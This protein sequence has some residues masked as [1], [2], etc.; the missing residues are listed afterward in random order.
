MYL[1]V[2]GRARAY[3]TQSDGTERTLSVFEPGA[4]FGEMALLTH[5]TRSA[6]V[7]AET[8]SEILALDYQALERIRMRFPYT[9]AK[10]FRNL[11]HMLS[12]RLRRATGDLVG[13]ARVRAVAPGLPS[14]LRHPAEDAVS[15]R[16]P[17]D[18]RGPCPEADADCPARST[19][20]WPAAASPAPRSRRRFGTADTR[21]WWSSRDSTGPSGCPGS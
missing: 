7:V 17:P 21:C 5:E 9:G 6:N 2:S 1:L 14:A 16:A 8:P 18:T 13:G 12:D 3:D 15:R 19:W 10:V 20:S 11:A 4:T